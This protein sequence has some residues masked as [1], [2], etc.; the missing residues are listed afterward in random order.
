MLLCDKENI[1]SYLSKEKTI[2]A[3]R[4]MKKF[5]DDLE[6][7]MS[8][9]GFNLLDNLGRRNILLSQAQEKF[10]AEE[11]SNDYNVNC[12]GRTGEPDILIECLGRELEC[13]LTSPHKSG[14]IAFQTDY[15]TLLKKK[16]LDYLYVVADSAFEKF[17][18]IHYND[19]TTSDFRNL[20]TGA[21]GKT[22][23]KKYAAHDRANILVGKLTS[24]NELE[25]KKLDLKLRSA[26]TSNQ[27][28]RLSK[29]VK[30]WKTTPTKFKVEM[31]SINA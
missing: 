18:V 31:E 7:L 11:L 8:R 23:M 12:D 5:H 26:K 15:E 21:R 25:L 30:Y 17:A 27:K 4:K 2:N 20:S 19:L 6:V 28:A 16:K 13:K 9:N 24:I 1:L 22:Q 3:L 14:A 10:F 29:S